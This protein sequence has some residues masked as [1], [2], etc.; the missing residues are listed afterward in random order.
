MVADGANAG[1]IGS[2]LGTSPEAHMLRKMQVVHS[3]FQCLL[4]KQTP[5]CILVCRHQQGH[6]GHRTCA[7]VRRHQTSR[8]RRAWHMCTCTEALREGLKDSV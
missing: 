6:T 7:L 4:L 1:Q 8:D 5:P 3:C 2:R